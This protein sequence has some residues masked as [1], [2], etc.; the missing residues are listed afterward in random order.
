MHYSM[1][2]KGHGIP[3]TFLKKRITQSMMDAMSEMRSQFAPEPEDHPIP[4]SYERLRDGQQLT[5]GEHDWEVIIGSGHSPEHVCLY[6]QKPDC[7]S[8]GIKY[9]RSSHP[10]CRFILPNL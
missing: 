9:Y 4:S 8:L 10:T 7:S 1:Q 3:L 5:I 6:S 2:D